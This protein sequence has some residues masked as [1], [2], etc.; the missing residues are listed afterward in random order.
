[1]KFGGLGVKKENQKNCQ[2]HLWMVPS[3]SFMCFFRLFFRF[4][5][6][7]FEDVF[8][9]FLDPFSNLVANQCSVSFR[10]EV[11]AILF[12]FISTFSSKKMQKCF[13]IIQKLSDR[14][15][16]GHELV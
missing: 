8:E 5:K 16:G 2:R 3:R 4:F 15:F 10:I 7:F 9:S 6:D 1:M 11:L 13:S 12:L 14:I